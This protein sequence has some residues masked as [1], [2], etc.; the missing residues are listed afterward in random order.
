M[1]PVRQYSQQPWIAS[2]CAEDGRRVKIGHNP[3]VG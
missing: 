2:Q 3:I 1:P